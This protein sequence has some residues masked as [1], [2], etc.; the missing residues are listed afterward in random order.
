MACE[1][2]P[3]SSFDD[4]IHFLLLSIPAEWHFDKMLTSIYELVVWA[5]SARLRT[6]AFLHW[7]SSEKHLLIWGFRDQSG[8]DVWSV[9]QATSPDQQPIRLYDLESREATK[10]TLFSAGLLTLTSKAII[11]G[12]FD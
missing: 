5:K 12:D 10:A 2:L 1:A 9:W 4:R 3:L 6:T 11:A 7:S 8:C